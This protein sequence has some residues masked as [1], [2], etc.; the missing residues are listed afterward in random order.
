MSSF[1]L[2]NI[3]HLLMYWKEAK[4]SLEGEAE[5]AGFVHSWRQKVHRMSRPG[6]QKLHPAWPWVP[7][8]VSTW[9]YMYMWP[10]ISPAFL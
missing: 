10:F 4:G 1:G 2:P 7:H 5:R 9:P 6:C 8:P 3:R